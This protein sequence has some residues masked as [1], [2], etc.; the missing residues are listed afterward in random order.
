MSPGEGLPVFHTSPSGG[1]ARL[2]F[3]ARIGRA[4]C[5]RARSA[6]KKDGLAAPPPISSETARCAS[7]GDSP[8]HPTRC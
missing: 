4:L 5:Y 8:G 3:P 1:A 6:S 7:T 2:S